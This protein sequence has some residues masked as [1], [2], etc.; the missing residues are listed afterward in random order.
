M[1]VVFVGG[2]FC[3]LSV[4]VKEVTVQV[5]ACRATSWYRYGHEYGHGEPTATLMLV[6]NNYDKT[7]VKSQENLFYLYEGLCSADELAAISAQIKKIP[8]YE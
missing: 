3:G 8:G 1:N 4:P 7:Q 6:T 2:P 5:M